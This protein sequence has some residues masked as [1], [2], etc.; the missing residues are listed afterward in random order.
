M[1]DHQAGQFE[2]VMYVSKLVEAALLFYKMESTLGELKCFL[3]PIATKEFRNLGDAGSAYHVADI[4][5][6]NLISDLLE[7]RNEEELSDV[8]LRV[9][10]PF[11]DEDLV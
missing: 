3:S 4:N 7:E 10:G 11:L 8:R 6:P 2:A 1:T 5:V 9:K